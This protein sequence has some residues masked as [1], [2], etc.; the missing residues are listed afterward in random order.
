MYVLA[1][2]FSANHVKWTIL[3]KQRISISKKRLKMLLITFTKQ[4]KRILNWASIKL[5]FIPFSSQ[6]SLLKRSYI[7]DCGRKHKL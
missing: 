5:Y 1:S 3:S 4:L 2:L 7:P 6:T